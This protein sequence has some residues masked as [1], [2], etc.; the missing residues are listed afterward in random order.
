MHN[1]KLFTFHIWL[2]QTEDEVE[3][4]GI[5]LTPCD[6]TQN[7]PCV[8]KIYA[9]FYTW[10]PRNIL[11][12]INFWFHANSTMTKLN[13]WSQTRLDSMRA[14]VCLIK[15][16]HLMPPFGK[17]LTAPVVCLSV[18]VCKHPS[19]RQYIPS[20]L[21]LRLH[22]MSPSLSQTKTNRA[23]WSLHTHIPTTHPSINPHTQCTYSTVK[24]HHHP[25]TLSQTCIWHTKTRRTHIWARSHKQMLTHKEHA[26]GARSRFPVSLLAWMHRH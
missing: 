18:C 25:R 26:F 6:Y 16:Y 19:P 2:F 21:C 9:K 7:L 24:H 11:K 10:D 3:V 13:Q 23:L 12:R 20:P 1:K 5:N 8:Y 4:G 15:A 17:W 14:D 22:C